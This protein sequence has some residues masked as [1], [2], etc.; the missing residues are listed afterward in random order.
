MPENYQ[1]VFFFLFQPRA[2]IRKRQQ[3]L[4]KL[5]LEAGIYRG[6]IKFD[7]EAITEAVN[8]KSKK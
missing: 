2:H 3:W 8:P 4:I 1:L 6:K 5:S 7:A